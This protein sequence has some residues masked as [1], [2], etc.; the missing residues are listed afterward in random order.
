MVSV[1]TPEGRLLEYVYMC[2]HLSVM[3]VY[4]LEKIFPK[5]AGS[6]RGI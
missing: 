3:S 5:M 6:G 2:V 1:R 4:T